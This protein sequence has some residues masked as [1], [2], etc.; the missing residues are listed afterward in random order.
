MVGKIN[1]KA[2]ISRHSRVIKDNLADVHPFVAFYR[3][4]NYYF[5]LI[6]VFILPI[7]PSFA[8]F[9]TPASNFDFDRSSIDESTIIDSFYE[10]GTGQSSWYFQV[11]TI[12]DDSRDRDW[13]NE[14][15]NYEIKAWDNFTMLA[16]KFEVTKNSIYWANDLKS[17]SELKIGQIIK[18]PSISWMIHTVKE[19]DT[20]ESISDK[21]WISKDNIISQNRLTTTI[22]EEDMTLIIPWA[23]KEQ[24]KKETW[25]YAFATAVWASG[26]SKYIVDDGKYPYKLGP[27]Q[28]LKWFYAGQCTSFVAQYKNV[29]WRWNAKDWYKNAQAKWVPTWKTAQI[30]SIIVFLWRWYHPWYWHVWIVMDV[31]ENTII[32]KDMNYRRAYE[33]TT[34]EIP[35]DDRAIMWYI[36]VD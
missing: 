11:N 2:R 36:Y 26:Q 25:W 4:V 18:I 20:L 24:P 3:N 29:T 9:L 34:R 31:R 10:S 22:L 27:K 17:D 19:N 5:V 13:V 14:V 8:I 21:Y 35:I 16:K 28:W 1:L 30:W 23:K 12:L 6:L 7:Y 32:V 15:I 33:V